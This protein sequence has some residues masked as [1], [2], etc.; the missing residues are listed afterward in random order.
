MSVFLVFYL[1]WYWRLT[2]KPDL[3][4]LFCIDCFFLVFF[5]TFSSQ[6]R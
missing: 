6:S 5:P 3:L 1:F 2:N 4:T